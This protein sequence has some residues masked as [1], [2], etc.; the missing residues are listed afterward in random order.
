MLAW[1]NALDLHLNKK[2]IE[3]HIR[4]KMLQCPEEKKKEMG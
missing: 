3:M 4:N 2:T 1:P